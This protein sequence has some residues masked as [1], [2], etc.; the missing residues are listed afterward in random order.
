MTSRVRI[1]RCHTCGITVISQAWK[2]MLST[3]EAN[4]NQY[5]DMGKVLRRYKIA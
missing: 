5:E 4:A 3:S 2:Q 1:I